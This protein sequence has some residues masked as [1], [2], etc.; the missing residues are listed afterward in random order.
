MSGPH[1]ILN[2]RFTRGTMTQAM[3]YPGAV[4]HIAE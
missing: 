4:K 1:E 3:Q 2:I